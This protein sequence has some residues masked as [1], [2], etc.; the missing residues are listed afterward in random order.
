MSHRILL[1]DGHPDPA[2][3]R[4]LHALTRSYYEGARLGGHEVRCVILSRLHFPLLRSNEEFVGDRIPSCIQECQESLLWAD[5]LVL[6]Y[7]LWLGDMPAM[8]KGF[9]EQLLRPG[10][11]LPKSFLMRRSNKPLAGRSARIIVTMSMPASVYRV[12]FGAHSL[13]AL[14]RNVLHYCG[15]RPVRSCVI[16]SVETAG[17][18]R[19]GIWLARMQEL[20]KQAS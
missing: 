6:L 9:L 12:Y 13:K 16:G 2:A 19:R 17:S 11:A 7:P 1:I 5:H 15:I 10:F 4:F 18:D 14:R 20:G 8:L 3:E